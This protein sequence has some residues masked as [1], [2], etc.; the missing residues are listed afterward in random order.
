MKQTI[1]EYTFKNTIRSRRPHN[2]TWGNLSHLYDYFVHLEEDCGIEF[3]F[4][5]IGIC[6]EYS[7][8]ANLEEFQEAY[9][10]D[11]ETLEDIEYNTTVIIGDGESFIIQ[12]F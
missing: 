4:D 11:Y 1:D 7:E 2:F 10:E 6:C 9:G 12:Q 3:D 5:P 8:Y